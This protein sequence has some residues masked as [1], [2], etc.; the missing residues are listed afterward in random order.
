MLDI[1]IIECECMN[2]IML[3]LHRKSVLQIDTVMKSI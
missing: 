1:L 3:E 2:V